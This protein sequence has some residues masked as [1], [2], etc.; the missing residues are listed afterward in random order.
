M[1]KHVAIYGVDAYGDENAVYGA[2]AGP[3]EENSMSTNSNRIS[4]DLTG[5]PLAAIN[6]ALDALEASP[7]FQLTLTPQEKKDLAKAAE[8][9]A[10]FM[11]K[12]ISYM[13]SH[14]QFIPGFLDMPEVNKDI[15]ARGHYLQFLLRVRNLM[16]KG[17]DAFMVINS[18]IYRACLAY[19]EA[20]ERA[21]G[22]GA[23]GAQPIYDD[24]SEEFPGRGSGP[25]TPPTPPTP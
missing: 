23:P 4:I 20:V 25:V 9:R 6:T 11:E 19:Y 10:G 5:A 15:A 17:E 21:A 18:E 8:K 2:V 13:G 7:A 22:M 3:V 1:P 12:C 16:A 14:A 24:L